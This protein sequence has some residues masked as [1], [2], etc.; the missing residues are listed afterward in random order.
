MLRCIVDPAESSSATTY[1]DVVDAYALRQ[2]V[3]D[4]D[5]DK[6]RRVLYLDWSLQVWLQDVD[7]PATERELRDAT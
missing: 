7:E 3:D 2:T 6:N 5:L 1:S 4:V